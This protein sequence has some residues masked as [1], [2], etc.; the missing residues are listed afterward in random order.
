METLKTYRNDFFSTIS[1]RK[2][3]S[4]HSISDKL[5][6]LIIKLGKKLVLNITEKKFDFNF[7]WRE[8]IIKA[9]YPNDELN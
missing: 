2:S 4:S 5:V 6:L 3:F 9:L 8:S 1:A 7:F